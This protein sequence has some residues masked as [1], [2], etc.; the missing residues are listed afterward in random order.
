ML[1]AVQVVVCITLVVLVG[2]WLSRSADM[3]AEKTGLGR[4]WA[5][6][7]LLAGATTL[8]ELATGISAVVI[9]NAPDLAAGGVFGSCLFNLCILVVLDVASGPG[10]LFHRIYTGHTLAAGLGLILLG[11]AAAAILLAQMG[12]SLALGWIGAPSIIMI[13]LYVTSARL[14]ARFEVRRRAAVLQQEAEVYQYE[15]V[16]TWRAY[17]TFGFTAVA[18]LGL[19]VWLTSLADQVAEV[20]GLGRSFVGA[21]LLAT[22]TSMP[23]LVASVSA[24]RFN[25]LDLSVSNIFGANILNMTLLG[26]YDLFYLRGSIWAHLSQIHIFTAIVAMLMTAI[27]IVGLIYRATQRPRFYI[28]W[29]GLALIALY[30][31]GMYVIF[32]S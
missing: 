6:A 1:L 18:I 32:R 29:D 15:H 14:I 20:T 28:N 16:P 17:L 27:A 10:P 30:I 26:V 3:L 13:I 8:P 5:G 25:A 2:T 11:I 7:I 19:G 23:E 22:A 9:F 12:D 4:T 21:L 24:I 31:G